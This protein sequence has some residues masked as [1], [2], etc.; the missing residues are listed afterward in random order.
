MKNANSSHRRIKGFT[1]IELLVTIAIIAI[2]A[3]ILFPVFARAREQARKSACMSNLK[4]IG[5]GVMMYVQDYDE[6]YPACDIMNT[7]LGT[8]QAEWYDVIAPYMKNTQVFVCP[9]AGVIVN[10]SGVKVGNGGYGWN[11]RGTGSS[12]SNFNGFGYRS[13]PAGSTNWGTP[14]KNAVKLA[15]VD[16]PATTIL[17]TDPA[18]NGTA[19]NGYAALGYL[20]PASSG[21]SYIPVL[22]GG[23]VGPFNKSSIVAVEPGGGGNYLF[24]DGHVKFLN[25]S[26]SYCNIMW[27]V[28]KSLAQS[29]SQACGTLQQ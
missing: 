15:E 5:I 22:H 13:G 12:G 19:N 21:L 11:I 28:S 17:V 3:A 14:S 8:I 4:Q 2:L 1:L 25:A 29:T 27:D 23:Q 6:S 18:S 26:Q 7:D 16:E 20:A 24:S 10:S 9:S